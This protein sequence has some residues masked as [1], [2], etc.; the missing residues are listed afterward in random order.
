MSSTI[1]DINAGWAIVPT[2]A[3]P[4]LASAGLTYPVTEPMLAD[5]C[6]NQASVVPAFNTCIASAGCDAAA[7]AIGTGFISLLPNVCSNL[8]GPATTSSVDIQPSA[9]VVTQ[10]PV[11]SSVDGPSPT[12]T[13]MPDPTPST[14]AAAEV[15]ASS[16]D[17]VAAPTSTSDA[18]VPSSSAS[19]GT[20]KTTTAVVTSQSATS[21]AATSS[22]VSVSVTSD[23]IHVV[24]TVAGF[25]AAL[26]DIIGKFESS[27]TF[28]PSFIMAGSLDLLPTEVAQ[29]IFAWTSPLSVCKYRRL[30]RHVNGW[31]LDRHFAKLN[32]SR[33]LPRPLPTS[34]DAET[35][36][37]CSRPTDCDRAWLQWPSAFQSVYP[38]LVK[39]PCAT[40][41][42]WVSQGLTGSLPCDMTAL[43]SLAYLDLR[44]NQLQGQIPVE[45]CAVASSLVSLLFAGNQLSGP[46]PPELSKL[47]QLRELDLRENQ[48]TGNLPSSLPPSLKVLF[49][50]AN[51]LS[52]S[53]PDALFPT[54]T[55]LETLGLSRNRFT[56]L[57]P[58]APSLH[59][60]DAS[61]NAFSDF[62]RNE[63]AWDMLT[64]LYA[65][66]NALR[67]CIPRALLSRA[68]GLR[69]LHLEENSLTCVPEEVGLARE[70][71]VLD[72][73][74]NAL[75][76]TLPAGLARLERLSVLAFAGNPDLGTVLPVEV[77]KV[78]QERRIYTYTPVGM[79]AGS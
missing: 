33:F 73:S 31:L 47:T 15:S 45:I 68:C 70:L 27:F 44:H 62:P 78:M 55:R 8:P 36:L 61:Q 23:A 4:C 5:V 43:Q 56:G 77:Q 53:I 48:L 63:D 54:L 9:S 25:L 1:A 19:H 49:L 42:A 20:V 37:V 76:G 64:C 79:R 52:G 72:V 13:A 16:T 11:A 14:T 2:C 35:N 34:D 71:V 58:S 51:Q 39:L 24:A 67:G 21:K 60:L 41:I 75:T 46:I 7:L 40:T 59:T 57:L 69:V 26:G 38:G 18:G 6:D 28:K 74:N 29:D 10:D 30:N 50:D 17:S 32:L 65:Q 3:L 22:M 66:R 12:T